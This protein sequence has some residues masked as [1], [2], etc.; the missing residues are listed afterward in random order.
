MSCIGSYVS[1]CI[2]ILCGRLIGYLGSA[3][4]CH[5]LLG[6]LGDRDHGQCDDFWRL[7]FID[8]KA[9]TVVQRWFSKVPLLETSPKTEWI[10]QASIS[11]P[12]LLEP[13]A[14]AAAQRW[15]KK[16]SY[17]DIGYL[18]RSYFEVW[19]LKAYTSLT[20][21]GEVS[22]SCKNFNWMRD[23][24]NIG[25]QPI[26]LEDLAGWAKLE[27]TTHWHSALGWTLFSAGHDD[28]ALEHCQKAIELVSLT[29]FLRR[30]EFVSLILR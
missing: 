27:E 12:T 3:E 25:L 18:D 19:F 22:E 24:P 1:D 4:G 7:W 29:F 14:R 8:Q 11:L 26:E 23:A 20:L 21:Y 30:F 9:T 13:L 2:C 28:A 16:R 10:S 6:G 17:D 5:G 15:L